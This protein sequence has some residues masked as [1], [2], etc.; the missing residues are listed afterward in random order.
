MTRRRNRISRRTFTLFKAASGSGACLSSF[1]LRRRKKRENIRLLR[2]GRPVVSSRHRRGENF[3]CPKIFLCWGNSNSVFPRRNWVTL[4]VRESVVG[5][6]FFVSLWEN[7]GTYIL[8]RRR[9]RNKCEVE[10]ETSDDFPSYQ[11]PRVRL[12]EIGS[13]WTFSNRNNHV[14]G[15]RPRGHPR[16]TIGRHHGALQRGRKSDKNS[17]NVSFITFTCSCLFGE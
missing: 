11:L 12:C 2:W 17:T 8:Q 1:I 14:S 6:F 5:F 15:R 4:W 13:V 9:R 16:E 7:S 10:N 3:F